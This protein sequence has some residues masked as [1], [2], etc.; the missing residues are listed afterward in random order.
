M[1][2]INYAEK[3][4]EAW[5]EVAPIHRKRRKI[6]LRQAVQS[7]AFCA[8]TDVEKAMFEKVG[9]AGKRVA[10]FCCNNGRE[11]IS[12]VK[13]GAASS[14]GFDIADEVV[15]EAQE[16]AELGEVACE[17]VRASIY[18]IPDTYNGRFD[19]V[20]VSTG[21][22]TWIDDVNRF[23]LKAANV[24]KDDGY[25]V[26]Y[27]IHPFLDMMTLPGEE[28]YDARDELKIAYT[29]FK[30]DPYIDEN[31]L[32][33]IGKTTYEGKTSYSFAHTLSDVLTGLIA[34]RLALLHIREYPDDI[35]ASFQSLEKYQ[36][37][38]MSYSV[39]AQKMTALPV[40]EI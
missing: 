11:L 36:K 24:L 21:A 38:P 32:D 3:N 9:L 18:E 27:E 1:S 31:G 17:F 25:V 13:M 35:S 29:Y 37:L 34:N 5:N 40:W 16:L 2:I 20:Y 8:L 4:R 10:H 22:L 12:L 19:I 6:D 15:K 14:V 39:V 28:E 7:P 26:M 30:D 33:Y 23:F